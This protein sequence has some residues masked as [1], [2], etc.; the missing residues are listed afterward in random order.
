[1]HN[2]P[3]SY[4]PE[5]L[6]DEHR[7][8]LQQ[9]YDLTLKDDA[10]SSSLSV[11]SSSIDRYLRQLPVGLQQ[12]FQRMVANGE[13]TNKLG[14]NE[15]KP[16]Y[17]VPL[18]QH[19]LDITNVLQNTPLL[20]SSSSSGTIHHQLLSQ[21]YLKRLHNTL[22]H[23]PCYEYLIPLSRNAPHSLNFESSGSAANSGSINTITF[24]TLVSSS[25]TD[26]SVVSRPLP[27]ATYLK[28]KAPSSL[29]P[30]HVL[31][32]LITYCHLIR[33]YAG[34]WTDNELDVALAFYDLCMVFNPR[35]TPQIGSILSSIDVTCTLTLETIV[36][37]QP[38]YRLSMVPNLYYGLELLNDV[39]SIMKEPHY[40]LDALT[41][42]QYIF[43]ICMEKLENVK[44][45]P[46]K[47]LNR[48]IPS[49]ELSTQI[50]MILRKVLFFISWAYHTFIRPDTDIN[51]FDRIDQQIPSGKFTA[52][53]LT[54]EIYEV[55]HERILFLQESERIQRKPVDNVASKVPQQT[56]NVIIEEVKEKTIDKPRNKSSGVSSLPFLPENTINMDKSA[57]SM[58]SKSSSNVID[59]AINNVQIDHIPSSE[60]TI[61]NESGTLSFQD[62]KQQR[63]QRRK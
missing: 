16:W 21:N 13:L 6:D 40:I 34:A 5:E 48:D 41:H 57:T 38:A 62:L 11:S 55:L 30:Y 4:A 42:I 50:D 18:P 51:E 2:D 12:K 45:V 20:L 39:C 60:E 36:N 32:I 29:L 7:Q 17:T 22:N 15:W 31:N 54:N 33:L 35:Y 23:Q 59:V 53:Q 46:L 27:L 52:N 19:K 47:E 37:S 44:S 10:E 61:N 43:E 24:A 1:M 58:V 49:K 14:L 56:R 8:L 28:H 26:S 3:D 9:L 63:R 25:T